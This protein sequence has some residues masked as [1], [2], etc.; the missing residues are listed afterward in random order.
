MFNDCKQIIKL[1]VQ[2]KMWYF[3]Y[4]GARSGIHQKFVN[5][6]NKIKREK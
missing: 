4:E 1:F 2:N 5:T 6:I 3:S